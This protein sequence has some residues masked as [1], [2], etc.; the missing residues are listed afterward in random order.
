VGHLAFR[1]LRAE[2]R[3]QHSRPRVGGH[4]EGHLVIDTSP[5]ATSTDTTR[6]GAGESAVP[7]ADDR[8]AARAA[9]MTTTGPRMFSLKVR[10]TSSQ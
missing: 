8:I 1:E 4:E 10:P 7:H 6:S 3:G 2:W 9:S 5:R